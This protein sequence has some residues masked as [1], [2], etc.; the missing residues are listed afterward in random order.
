MRA[1]L[2]LMLSGAPPEGHVFALNMQTILSFLPHLVNFALLA[3]ILTKL[4]YKP[5]KEMLHKRAERVLDQLNNARDE[6]EKATE[7]KL[8][9]E[10]RLKDIEAER[11]GII[12]SARKT[13]T[14]TSKS[15][16][17]DA[18]KESDEILARAKVNIE[19]E[20]ERAKEEL[21]LHII[22]VSSAMTEKFLVRSIAAVDHDRM[23]DETMAELEEMAWRN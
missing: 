7:L 20:R 13:A 10:Q 6:M 4:L 5:V 11:D 9:Y 22:Q 18:K 17:A 3:F 12:D 19:L 23:F 14:D 21:R 8:Q 2:L 15:I 16:L 1:D